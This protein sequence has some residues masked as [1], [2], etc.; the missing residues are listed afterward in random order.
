MLF[1]IS[2]NPSPLDEGC[3]AGP[4]PPNSLQ[5]GLEFLLQFWVLRTSLETFGEAKF[6]V[7][8]NEYS[9]LT[10]FIPV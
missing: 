10:H 4:L 7:C 1:R 8:G 3:T 9:L 2:L 6:K 5:K